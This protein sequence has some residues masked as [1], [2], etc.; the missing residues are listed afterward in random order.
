MSSFS[1]TQ[2]GLAY[3]NENNETKSIVIDNATNTIKFEQF[4][5]STPSVTNVEYVEQT[6]PTDFSGSYTDVPWWSGGVITQTGSSAV[7][8]LP[9]NSFDGKSLTI[10]GN[11]IAWDDNE[12]S[13]SITNNILTWSN[14]SIWVRA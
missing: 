7:F 10:T 9:G 1:L 4:N 5:I 8:T 12:F 13:G 6:P 11:L 14:G 2:N 3:T